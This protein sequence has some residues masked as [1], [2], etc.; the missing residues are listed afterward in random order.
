MLQSR[1]WAAHREATRLAAA[2]LAPATRRALVLERPWP[3]SAAARRT[4]RA[5][6]CRPTARRGE[7]TARRR[8]GRPGARRARGHLADRGIDVVAADPEVAGRDAA[9]R[10]GARGGRVPAIP[11][12]QP[13]R[14]RMA[15]PL[16]R[17][18]RGRRVRRHREGDPPADPAGRARRVVVVRWDAAP[19]TSRARSAR[20]RTPP[21]PRPVLRPAPRDG[22]PARLQVRGPAEFV[23]WWRRAHAAGHLV[24][25]EAREGAADGDVLGGLVLYRH[26]RRLST[27]HSGDRAERR[28]DH[29]GAMHLL[30]WRA[31]QLALAEGRTEMDLG[32]VDLAGARRIPDRGRADVRPVRA[33]AVVRGRVGGAG[34]RPGAGR[35]AVALRAG[36]RASRGGA[37][38]DARAD[39]AMSDATTMRDRTPIAAAIAAAEPTEPRPLAGLLARLDA[40]GLLRGARRDGLPIGV[41]GVADVPVRGVTED[42]REVA[43]GTLFVAV[44]GLPRRRPRLRRR[45][46]GRGG[47][48]AAIVEHAVSRTP[49]PQLVVDGRPARA[50]PRRGAGGTATRRARWASSGSPGTDGKTTTSF[51]A[52]GRARG[53]GRS[54]R[55]PR[56][57]RDARSAPTRERHEAHVTTPG[58]PELQATLRGDGRVRATRPRSLETT[59]HALALDR[60]ARGRLRRR[61]PHQPEPRA[62]RSAR[63]VR[64]VPRGQAPAV[65][66]LAAGARTRRKTVGRPPVAQARGH[67][68]RRP[69]R[70]R[71]SRPPRAR[72]APPCSPTARTAAPT[73]APTRVEEDARRLRVGVRGAVRRGRARA[74]ARRPVQRPQ[75]ARRRRARRGPRPRPG[76]RPRGPRGRRAASRAGWSGSTRASR[77]RSSSTTPTR[78]PRSQASSTCSRRSPRPAAASSSPCSG[79]AASAT[80]PSAPLMGRIAGRALPPRRGDR[81][82]PP[83]RGPR[84]DHRRDRRAARRRRAGAEAW[85][86]SRSRTGARRSRPPSSARGPA[87]SCCSPARATSRRS[88]TRT[89]R[90]PGTRPRSPARR[91][92]RSGWR[93]AAMRGCL[94]TL[95]LGAGRHRAPRRRRAAADR[96]R[97]ASRPAVTAAGLQADDTTVTSASDPPTDLLGLH[98]DRVRVTRDRRD[99]PRP[100][101]RLARPR[102]PRRL[103]PRPHG[104][105]RRGQPPT[106]TD[107]RPRRPERRARAR[108]PS[109]AAAD[110]VTATTVIDGAEAEGL[111]A[112]AVEER[113]GVRPG[114]R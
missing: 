78:R 23:T 10:R 96:R 9:Y 36:P 72:R 80:R 89:A 47:A 63:H 70:H 52:V 22:R 51:L 73:S 37:R 27:A 101:D 54:D 111:V 77:S 5:G 4:C 103:D 76:R 56:H 60:V 93:P 81:R 24:Y 46:R 83:R 44:P 87:T 42:S 97:R 7:P 21:S 53:R 109:R 108:S 99:L 98:A 106:S 33:Q 82:G 48:A 26:G 3:G 38:R 1:A 61:D 110:D 64:G 35:A 32:G 114:R 16:R 85:T 40:A 13:S 58:A 91:S 17:P 14:H 28:R 107:R 86:C 105:R 62:P 25:L 65:R 69:G 30:R 71:G 92:R 45:G 68:P 41:S 19:T 12:I 29:P 2:F 67:Q 100:R 66:A 31:I 94:F 34:R 75:R 15:L 79:R 43:E 8:A 50:R 112:D 59:S 11:E 74:P 49:L 55:P 57:G 6:R 20:P 39:G 18:R 95:V 104:R 88:C 84:R 113:T 90:C 102:A